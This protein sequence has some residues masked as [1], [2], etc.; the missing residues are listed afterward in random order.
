MEKLLLRAFP[1]RRAWAANRWR[2]V[3]QRAGDSPVRMC[4]AVSGADGVPD[5]QES[6]LIFGRDSVRSSSVGCR[7]TAAADR[8]MLDCKVL[9]CQPAYRPSRKLRKCRSCI[10]GTN[11][12]DWD[13]RQEVVHRVFDCR[14][15]L[16]QCGDYFRRR[17]QFFFSN[18]GARQR[19]GD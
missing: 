5:P 4:P 15:Y 17:P 16:M 8:E 6:A 9:R 3:P 7:P 10:R 1:K 11:S 14:Q 18:I 2:R 13:N 19:Q 12:R